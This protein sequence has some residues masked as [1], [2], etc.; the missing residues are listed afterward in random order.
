[1]TRLDYTT[2]V[3]TETLRLYPPIWIVT[4]V[5]TTEA[6]LAGRTLPAGTIL[7]YSPYLIQRRPDLYPDPNRFN[8]DRWLPDHAATLP[9]GALIPF[10]G[11]A[12]KCIGDT[13]G[14]LE[15]TL[16]LASMTARWQLDPLPGIIGRPEWRQSRV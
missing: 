5:L 7:L 8:P 3:L 1:V 2:R 9:R 4:R 14:M 12:R 6:T 11:G 15:A 16:A 13:L 10:G